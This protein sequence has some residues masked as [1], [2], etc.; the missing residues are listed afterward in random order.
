MIQIKNDRG[1]AIESTNDDY[2]LYITI[3]N[4][5]AQIT[6]ADVSKGYEVHDNVTS[7]Y[8]ITDTRIEK[9]MRYIRKSKEVV[10]ILV[11]QN[12]NPKYSIKKIVNP[13]EVYKMLDDIENIIN[14][15]E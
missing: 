1:E 15:V 12:T 11:E 7:H 2:M 10:N 14:E 4:E 8:T 13:E 5:Q 3:D 9:L 6:K